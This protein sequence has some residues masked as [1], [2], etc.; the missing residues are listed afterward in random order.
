MLPDQK[1]LP[2][3]HVGEERKG[4]LAILPVEKMRYSERKI[5]RKGTNWEGRRTSA[6]EALL[7]RPA[8]VFATVMRLCAF[9]REN[10]EALWKVRLMEAAQGIAT[11]TVLEVLS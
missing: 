3:L 2:R 8:E 5:G 7:R 6:C 11:E 9:E 10:E 4:K 1:Y